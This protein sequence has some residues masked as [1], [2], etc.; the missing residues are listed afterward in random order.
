MGK[1]GLTS[2]EAMGVDAFE[3]LNEQLGHRAWRDGQRRGPE[4]PTFAF[5]KAPAAAEPEPDAN[6]GAAGVATTRVK[7][8]QYRPK[9]PKRK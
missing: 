2:L 9:Y 5:G 4:M 8:R 6:D 7:K 1:R 3:M